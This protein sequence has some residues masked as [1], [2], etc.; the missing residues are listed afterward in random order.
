MKKI[1][2]VFLGLFLAA[3]IY[4]VVAVG[5]GRYYKGVSV[6][7]PVGT[8]QIVVTTNPVSGVGAI[9]NEEFRLTGGTTAYMNVIIHGTIE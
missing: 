7:L 1:L 9:I 8:Y 3:S 4:A 2:S 6:S 5:K